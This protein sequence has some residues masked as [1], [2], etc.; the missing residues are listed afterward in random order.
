[1]VNGFIRSRTRLVVVHFRTIM[2][3]TQP[4]YVHRLVPGVVSGSA[5]SLPVLRRT[6]R[7]KRYNKFFSYDFRTK[8][9]RIYKIFW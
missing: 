6:A 4:K 8:K 5:V 7:F 1:M 9:A 2:L 3:S